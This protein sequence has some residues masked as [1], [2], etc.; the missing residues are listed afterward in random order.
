M[1]GP[2]IKKELGIIDRVFL[3]IEDHGIFALSIGVDFGGAH[4]STGA[5][6][7]QYAGSW[8]FVRDFLDLFG[9]HDILDIKGKTVFALYD[10]TLNNSYI[11]GFETP[12]FEGGRTLIFETASLNAEKIG[13]GEL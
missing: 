10:S 13:K 8:R 3:G 9:V 5:F 1:T 2:I 12:K 11:R 4:Q 6:N 7:L